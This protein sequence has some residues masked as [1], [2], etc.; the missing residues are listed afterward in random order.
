M[1][2][3][4]LGGE[5]S[6]AHQVRRPSGGLVAEERAPEG[7]HAIQGQVSVGPVRGPYRIAL[8][9]GEAEQAT[10]RPQLPALLAACQTGVVT[11]GQGDRAAIGLGHPLPVHRRLCT[12]RLSAAAWRLAL[13]PVAWVL[14]GRQPDARLTCTTLPRARY[15]M[16]ATVP[17]GRSRRQGLGVG[18]H[19]AG[20]VADA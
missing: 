6:R 9:R 19:L 14:S 13:A 11:I 7:V 10:R 2:P 5:H 8:R 18:V 12:F 1:R 17:L 3:D 20:T 15:G 4:P 16:G